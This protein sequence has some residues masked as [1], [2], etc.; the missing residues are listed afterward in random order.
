MTLAQDM[1]RSGLTGR[2]VALIVAG[3]FLTITAVDVFMITS[4]LQSQPGLVTDHAYERGLA[5][6]AVLAA[7][8]RQDALGW[9][10]AYERVDGQLMISIKDAAGPMAPDDLALR[11]LRPS[12]A[13]KDRPLVPVAAGPGR[14]TVNLAEVEAGLWQVAI[15]L[16][17]GDDRFDRLDDLVLP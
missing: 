3:F 11:L 2:K 1:S 12:D 8:A 5:Y 17:R 16:R 9:S 7:K 6:N 15:S 14:Y 4:A 10:V 13:G